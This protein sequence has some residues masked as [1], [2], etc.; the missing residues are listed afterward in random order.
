MGLPEYMNFVIQCSIL[1]S[2]EM[3]KLDTN[4]GGGSLLF[5]VGHTIEFVWCMGG[6]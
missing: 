1:V 6:G 5:C 3:N 2:V 4:G